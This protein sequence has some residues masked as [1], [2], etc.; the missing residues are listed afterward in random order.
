MAIARKML[1]AELMRDRRESLGWTLAEMAHRTGIS[2]TSL[3][4]LE[5]RQSVDPRLSTTKAICKAYG[6]SFARIA[7][8][9]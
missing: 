4:Q 9:D 7:D 1:L 6:F 2:K 8:F 5:N 3:W